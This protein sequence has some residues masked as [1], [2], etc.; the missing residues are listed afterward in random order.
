ML[1]AMGREDEAYERYAESADLYRRA[2]GT[3]H[4]RTLETDLIV[5]SMM[6]EK[7]NQDRAEALIE[8]VIT[9]SEESLGADHALTASAENALEDLQGPR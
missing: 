1:F 6:A 4:R 5:A 3:G 7:G 2:L 8:D 9:R